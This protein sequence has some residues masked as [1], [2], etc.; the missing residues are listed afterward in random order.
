MI[1]PASSGSVTI[2]RAAR[3]VMPIADD[4]G[5]CITEFY[6]MNRGWSKPDARAGSGPWSTSAGRA[7]APG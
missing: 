3:S 4:F 7:S 5:C 1:Y 2:A 6:F